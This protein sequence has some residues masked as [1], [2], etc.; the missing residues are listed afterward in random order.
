[1]HILSAVTPL[2]SPP[3]LSGLMDGQPWLIS[4][5][6]LVAAFA[7]YHFTRTDALSHPGRAGAAILVLAAIGLQVLAAAITT[8][9]ERIAATTSLLVNSTARADTGAV[10]LLLADDARLFSPSSV[11]Q[12]PIPQQGLDKGGILAAIGLAVGHLYPL[13]DHSIREIQAETTSANTGRTQVMVRVV[14]EATQFPYTSWWR[15]G[16]RKSPAGE[17]KAIS[18]EPIEL[19]Y[20]GLGG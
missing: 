17:W 9:R 20:A 13:K 6:L 5:I 19:P 2:P 16:W 12:V 7:V 14:P 15:I 1:M 18:I 8:D 4:A 3:P 11:P 10:S